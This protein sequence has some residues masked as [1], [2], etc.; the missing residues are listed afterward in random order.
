MAR[1]LVAYTLAALDALE[2]RH[3]PTHNELIVTPEGPCLV[4]CN[5]RCHGGGGAW[6]ELA[7]ALAGGPNQVSATVD[8]YTNAAAFAG[9]AAL[10]PSPPHAC[11]EWLVLVSYHTGHILGTPG[12]EAIRAL[13]SVAA[14]HPSVHVG[15]R[16][17]RTVDMFTIA[18]FAILMHADP[19]VVARDAAAIRSLET[20][21]LFELLQPARFARK[22]IS[23]S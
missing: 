23:W 16:L 9:L 14:L 5:C 21:G 13:P 7:S 19:E 1:A 15:S 18:G 8:A 11:G 2:I 3:G 22:K 17:E 20:A 10:P 4:E 12:F 6:M